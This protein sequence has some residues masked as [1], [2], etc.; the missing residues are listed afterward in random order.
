MKV[1]VLAFRRNERGYNVAHV[2][3]GDKFGDC[4]AAPDLTEPGEYELRSV[5]HFVSGRLVPKIRVEK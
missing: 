5:I 2:K 4:L 3:I 1:N